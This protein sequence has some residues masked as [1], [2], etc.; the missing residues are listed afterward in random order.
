MGYLDHHRLPVIDL[1]RFEAGFPWRQQVAAQVDRASCRFGSFQI[2]GHGVDGLLVETLAELNG[3]LFALGADAGGEITFGSSSSSAC[4]AACGGPAP[5]AA[6]NSYQ[7]PGLREAVQE[8]L[9]VLTG[10]GHKLMTLFAR[11]LSL[12][13][14]YFV[15]RYTGNPDTLLRVV[16]HSS[17]NVP[18]RTAAASQSSQ[19]LRS[20]FLTLVMPDASGGLAVWHQ[21]RRVELSTMPG[22]LVCQVGPELERLSSGRYPA[23][24]HGL[25]CTG[26]RTQLSLVFSFEPG[27]AEARADAPLAEALL[28]PLP[29]AMVDE[30]EEQALEL[31]PQRLVAF[32]SVRSADRIGRV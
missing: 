22:A 31:M 19:G 18:Q 13:D 11:G 5:W 15:D 12:N 27:D 8:Y 2:V 4:R 16:A 24:R 3:K 14:G 26:E 32:K 23:A 29:V 10:L 6:Q 30:E 25:H 7:L 9:T 20:K 1:S 21:D 17:G 28:E